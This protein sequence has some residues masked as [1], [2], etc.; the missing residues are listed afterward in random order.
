MSMKVLLIR[1]SNIFSYNN[2]P[3]LGL[4][5]IASKLRENGYDVRIINCALEA[6]PFSTIKKELDGSLLAGITVLTSEIP[7]AYEIARFVKENSEIP[8]VAGGWHCT[9]FPDQVADSEYF[10]YVVAGEGESHMLE[11]ADRVR[12]GGVFEQKIFSS[13]I[14]DM[15]K[16]PVPDYTL[17]DKI[18]GFINNYL[19]DKLSES[20][21]Q[22]MRWLPYQSSRGCP[23]LC[24]FCINVVTGNTR[25]RKKSA[26]KV[27][28][29][30]EQIVKKHNLTHLKII[31]DNFFVDIKR[32]STI[33]EGL[34]E[35]NLGIT[36]DGECRC[37]YFT[38]NMINDETLT[39]LKQSGLVQL[40]LGIESGSSHTL[41]IMKKGITTEQAEFA[42]KRCG[43][44]GIIAR[45]SFIIELPG[46][47]MGDIKKTVSFVNRLRSHPNFTC[48]IQTFRPYPKCELTEK[49]VQEGLINEPK[50]LVEWTDHEVIKMYVSARYI[51]P[52]QV[53]GKY[54]EA[55]ADYLTLESGASLGRH[56]MD[57][58]ID[59]LKY[60]LF[61][62]LA[63]IRNRLAFYGFPFD[64]K[65]YEKFSEDFYRRIQESERIDERKDTTPEESDL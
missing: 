64:K 40:T 18:E 31:D 44:Y 34:I 41:A 7:S 37:D 25:Y 55:A 58:R 60:G 21:S 63:K 17:D 12:D 13:Q 52:W 54:S 43:D 27:I 16:L 32:V 49:L 26:Q 11:I 22:P 38:D 57:R 3:A 15:D 10:D 39:L 23:S 62:F 59:R 9:L 33:C 36:W 20:V 2:Y 1:P 6:D 29:E 51:A 4:I 8:V 28:N 48:G 46:E 14:L 50:T 53:N 35:L 45:S 30:I 47:T 42:V 56:Q 65:L 61:V 5:S 24:T 19:T